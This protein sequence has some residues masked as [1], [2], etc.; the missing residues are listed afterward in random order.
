MATSF[1]NT[2]TYQVAAAIVLLFFLSNVC[3][4]QKAN[5][6]SGKAYKNVVRFNLTNFL[7]FGPGNIIFGYERVVSPSQS[8][9]INIGP[10]A[11]PSLLSI[12]TDSVNITKQSNKSGFN[13]SADYRFY[14]RSENKYRAPHG[15]YI[16][17]YFMYNKTRKES[18]WEFVRSSGTDYV[19]TET[20]FT[21]V[22]A[23]L[24]LGYQFVFFKR[25]TLDLVLI[26]PGMARYS[27]NAKIDG[28][29]D[30]AEKKQLYQ[31]LQQALENK[32]PG[33][34][35]VL[36]DQEINANGRLGVTSVGFRYLIQVGFRF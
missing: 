21:V 19:N 35:V 6:E 15:L 7:L 23:G 22:G 10:A 16:G 36:D 13:V 1:R 20:N 31:A 29:L 24:E 28:S 33:M 9:S 25:M 14:L 17:P 5:T 30:D 2:G 32:Y 11:L 27:I 12:N 26:G 4:A 34:S 3:L 8:F 18:D